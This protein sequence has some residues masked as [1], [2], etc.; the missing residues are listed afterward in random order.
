MIV[1]TPWTSRVFDFNFPVGHFPA[2]YVRLLG[3]AARID[4]LVK[5]CFES[6]FEFKPDGRWSVKEHI[7]HLV[8]LEELHE[9]RLLD[10]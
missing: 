10:Y 1:K 5:N 6:H 2:I 4:G 8:D 9:E 7:G 3:T